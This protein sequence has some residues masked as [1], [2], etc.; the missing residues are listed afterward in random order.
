VSFVCRR[1]RSLNLALQ[2]CQAWR[3]IKYGI[4]VELYFRARADTDALA[5]RCVDVWQSCRACPATH[6]PFPQKIHVRVLTS[7]CPGTISMEFYCHLG[8][9]LFISHVDS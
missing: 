3:A 6:N 5:I 9:G 2:C 4:P 8:L 7:D 1:T